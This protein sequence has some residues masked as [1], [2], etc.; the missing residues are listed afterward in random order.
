MNSLLVTLTLFLIAAMF[1]SQAQAKSPPTICC[2]E[3]TPG[4]VPQHL[5][6][7]YEHTNSRCSRPAIIFTTKKDRKICADPSVAWVQDRIR[8]LS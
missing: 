6:K 4:P 1:L 8:E 3:Y 2:F 7:S 5:L